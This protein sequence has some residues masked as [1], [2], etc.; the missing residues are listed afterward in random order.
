MMY[1]PFDNITPVSPKMTELPG[2]VEE[3][4]VQQIAAIDR[5]LEEG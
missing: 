5:G 1:R 4:K 3:S 2:M